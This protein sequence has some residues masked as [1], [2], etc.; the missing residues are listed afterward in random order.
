M[1]FKQMIVK[2]LLTWIIFDAFLIAEEPYFVYEHL[3]V[4]LLKGIIV[5]LCIHVMEGAI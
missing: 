2:L 4:M 1:I 5:L 3:L